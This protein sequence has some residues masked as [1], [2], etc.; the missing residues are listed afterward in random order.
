LDGE[1]TVLMCWGGPRAPQ[2]YSRKDTLCR[3]HIQPGEHT[4]EFYPGLGTR[5]RASLTFTAL[6]GK[7]Y[8]LD[9]SACSTNYSGRQATCRVEIKEIQATSGVG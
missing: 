4:V 3:L 8:G 7:T 5:E 1:D 2:A 6:P 9:R